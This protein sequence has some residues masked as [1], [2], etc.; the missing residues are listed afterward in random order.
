MKVRRWLGEQRKQEAA[1]ALLG[2]IDA[3]RRPQLDR[4]QQLVFLELI[5]AGEKHDLL[6]QGVVTS[7]KQ[8]CAAAH[9]QRSD[10]DGLVPLEVPS[11]ARV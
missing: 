4:L 6:Q 1:A 11:W 5:D 3:E 2:M 10:R 9:W 8:G 7:E